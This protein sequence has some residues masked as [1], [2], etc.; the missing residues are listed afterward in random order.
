MNPIRIILLFI[1]VIV[2]FNSVY[3]VMETQSAIKLQFGRLTE[4]N[5]GAGLHVKIPF[6]ET[7]KRF[8]T[9]ILTL[10]ANEESYFTKDEERLRV[11]SFVKWRI[12]D[13]ETYYKA[14]GGDEDVALARLEARVNDGLRNE[15]G[16]RTLN[17]AVSGQRDELMEKLTTTLDAQAR[18]ALGIAVVDVRVK[19]ID[20]PEEVS[21][22]VFQQ[23]RADR[24]K[25]ARQFRSEGREQAEQIR[26][27][28]DRQRVVIEANAYREA[29]QLRGDGDANAAKIYADAYQKDPEFYAFMR[30]LEAYKKS[31]ASKAD[32]MLVDPD[33]EFFR[34]MQDSKG[35]K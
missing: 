19:R 32:M 15:L 21:D 17:E 30:S 27:D 7:I 26:A 9:R 8:D 14:T 2:G 20:F 18:E 31:F 6:A 33:S 3:R 16:D 22:S 10:D 11:D 29:E 1:V 24:E 12:I 23:M 25:E 5:I 35:K 28:A 34:Y 13:V 4:A